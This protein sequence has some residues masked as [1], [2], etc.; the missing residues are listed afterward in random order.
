VAAVTLRPHVPNISDVP[1]AS[2]S[3]AP[4]GASELADVWM[5]Q[6]RHDLRQPLMITSL[7]LDG[8]TAA[9]GLDPRTRKRVAEIQRQVD[10]MQDLLRTQGDEAS[11]DVVDLGETIAG[12][13][14]PGAHG[15][16]VRFVQVA[17]APILVDPVELTR[18]A[19]NLLDNATR[20]VGDTGTVQVTVTRSSEQAV[21]D[22]ADDGPGFGRMAPQHGHGLVSVRRFVE[23]HGG[24]LNF[25]TS[26]LGG[27]AVTL[28]LPLALS[29]TAWGMHT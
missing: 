11:V 16:D 14:T 4:D 26:A 19:R 2:W 13:C 20:A 28:H 10:W 23:R 29:H 6:F 3:P 18:V 27:A 24:R 9:T 7:L 12:H 17:P 21:L 22:V 1:H 25:G 5:Q 8:L 15:C